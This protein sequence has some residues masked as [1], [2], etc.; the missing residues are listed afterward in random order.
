MIDIVDDLE[1]C[2]VLRWEVHKR[3]IHNVVL[4]V[5]DKVITLHLK[6]TDKL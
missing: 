6:Y 1:K 5:N 4:V 3:E 2:P